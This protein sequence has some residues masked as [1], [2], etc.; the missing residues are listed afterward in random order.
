ML[1]ITPAHSKAYDVSRF[2]AHFYSLENVT[3]KILL[4]RHFFI[5]LLFALLP[6]CVIYVQIFVCKKSPLESC[7][8]A[9]HHC[10]MVVFLQLRYGTL[11][12]DGKPQA[13]GPCDA[14][15]FFF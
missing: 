3:E 12:T 15:Q 11:I 13:Y 6:D 9:W 5:L 2:I 7:D 10:D 1:T 14:G 8:C 4:L